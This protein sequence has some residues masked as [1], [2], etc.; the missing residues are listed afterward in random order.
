MVLVERCCMLVWYA[1]RVKLRLKDGNVGDRPKAGAAGN[2][3]EL[4]LESYICLPT[5]ERI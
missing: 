4:S 1:L 2:Q 5:W 3:E